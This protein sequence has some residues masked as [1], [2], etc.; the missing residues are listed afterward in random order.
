MSCNYGG[1]KGTE[2]ALLHKQVTFCTVLVNLLFF[3]LVT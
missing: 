2:T 1:V 3:A